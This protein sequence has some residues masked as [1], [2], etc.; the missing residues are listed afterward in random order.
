VIVIVKQFVTI[1]VSSF[2]LIRNDVSKPIADKITAAFINYDPLKEPDPIKY[3]LANL[4]Q[5]ITPDMFLVR[6]SFTLEKKGEAEEDKTE[7]EN[8]IKLYDG[9]RTKSTIFVIGAGEQ[10]LSSHLHDSGISVKNLGTDE[11]I[12]R[13]PVPTHDTVHEREFNKPTQEDQVLNDI[14]NLEKVGLECTALTPPEQR[15]ILTVLEW[16]ELKVCFEDTSIRLGCFTVVLTLPVPHLRLVKKSL[17]AYVAH[18]PNIDQIVPEGRKILQ[19]CLVTS[20]IAGTVL[21]LVL[22]DFGAALAAFV[23]VFENCVRIAAEQTVACLV[24]G[25]A[26]IDEADPFPC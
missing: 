14:V 3:A 12:G 2:L 22:L 5:D 13:V 24:P 6:P 1:T 25:L 8:I 26:L 10:N 18:L 16:P 19:T 9:S 7:L 20:A 17:F 4:G 21:G 23:A 15:K 11:L